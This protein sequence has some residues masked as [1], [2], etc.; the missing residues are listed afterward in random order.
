MQGYRGKGERMM[1]NEGVSAARFKWKN[2]ER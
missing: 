1:P 2:A